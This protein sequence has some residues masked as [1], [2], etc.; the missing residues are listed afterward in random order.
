MGKVK[1]SELKQDAEFHAAG[2][3]CPA[4]GLR[5]LLDI[6]MDFV[7]PYLPPLQRKIKED[8]FL[9]TFLHPKLPLVGQAFLRHMGH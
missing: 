5:P 1:G 4:P 9:S 2:N 7:K 8:K 6:H 3:L